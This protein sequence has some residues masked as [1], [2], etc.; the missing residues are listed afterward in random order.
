[1]G[2]EKSKAQA[3]EAPQS[4]RGMDVED[5]RNLYHQCL[6]R[7]DLTAEERHLGVVCYVHTISFLIFLSAQ[8]RV[9]DNLSF[10]L[11][12]YAPC[13]QSIEAQL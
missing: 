13:G 5:M 11:A 3:G 7:A 1:M 12:A 10:C 4:A 9:A 2:L 8:S 6:G